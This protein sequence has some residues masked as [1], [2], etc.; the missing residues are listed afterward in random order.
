MHNKRTCTYMR[1]NFRQV[2]IC[3]QY[4]PHVPCMHL[5]GNYCVVSHVVYANT[6]TRLSNIIIKSPYVRPLWYMNKI[7]GESKA[8]VTDQF[9]QQLLTDSNVF[10]L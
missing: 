6:D 10:F 4:V 1:A 2:I 8:G 7:Q 9:V 3:E 5:I